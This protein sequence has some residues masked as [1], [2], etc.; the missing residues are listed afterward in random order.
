MTT[1]QMFNSKQQPGHFD[2]TL[3]KQTGGPGQ[4]AR[5]VGYLEACNEFFAF[6]NQIT[7]GAIPTEYI[8]ACEQGFKDATSSGILAGYPVTGVKVVLTDGDFHQND[9]NDRAFQF[10]ACQGFYQGMSTADAVIIEPIM[11][12]VVT[13]PTA[14]IGAVQVNLMARRGILQDIRTEHNHTELKVQVPLSEM[15]GYATQLR[16]LTS[17]QGT[18]SMTPRDYQPVP[19]SV[20]RSLIAS[21]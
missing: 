21:A 16:S 15:F 11:D 2:Y 12:V 1:R 17:G 8:K 20:Q 3:R 19:E 13:I 6:D 5:V 14:C 4:Y 7:G 18:F 10:A 9:S